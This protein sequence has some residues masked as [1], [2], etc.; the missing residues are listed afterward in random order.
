MPRSAGT[1]DA[2]PHKLQPLLRS[3]YRLP[4]CPKHAPPK[5]QDIAPE[6]EIPL[7]PS[8]P[9]PLRTPGSKRTIARGRSPEQRSLRDQA[10]ADGPAEVTA[11]VGPLSSPP[12]EPAENSSEVG[13]TATVCS[14]ITAR[15]RARTAGP[16]VRGR[17]AFCSTCGGHGTRGLLGP[18]GLGVLHFPCRACGPTD[19]SRGT[20]EAATAL[21]GT[22]DAGEDAC[23][24]AE[25]AGPGGRRLVMCGITAAVASAALAGGGVALGMSIPV[26]GDCLHRTLNIAWMVHR[27]LRTLQ[28]ADAWV[29][30]LKSF[31]EVMASSL[32]SLRFCTAPETVGARQE[33][34][35]WRLQ[36]AVSELEVL[37]LRLDNLVAHYA[38]QH[39]VLRGLEVTK[40]HEQ[41]EEILA[42]ISLWNANVTQALQLLHQDSLQNLAD[43][44]R[45]LARTCAQRRS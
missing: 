8:Q 29:K 45:L 13:W 32:D 34:M 36:K 6:E 18:R 44:V 27:R 37:L 41:R 40:F 38:S 1:V 28:I 2:S 11:E 24:L 19:I 31:M 7:A 20:T 42:S 33:S 15:R 25:P 21:T 12:H 17:L 16:S 10:E 9:P 39:L 14:R 3:H 23:L 22:G 5:H 26:L 4:P 35:S 30:D 43:E